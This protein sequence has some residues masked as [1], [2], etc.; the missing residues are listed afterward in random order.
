MAGAFETPLWRRVSTLGLSK[1]KNHAPCLNSPPATR[2]RQSTVGAAATATLRRSYC[3][4]LLKLPKS[5][6]A[7][8]SP[9]SAPCATSVA[10][11]QQ[12]PPVKHAGLITVKKR[13]GSPS[14]SVLLSGGSVLRTRPRKLTPFKRLSALSGEPAADFSPESSAAARDSRP[15]AAE[16]GAQPVNR[17]SFTCMTTACRFASTVASAPSPCLP[18]RKLVSARDDRLQHMSENELLRVLKSLSA[19][20]SRPQHT[21]FTKRHHPATDIHAPSS[22]SARPDLRTAST[23]LLRSVLHHLEHSPHVFFSILH[24]YAASSLPPLELLAALPAV[25]AKDPRRLQ[26]LSA[27]ELAL[28]LHAISRLWLSAGWRPQGAGSDLGSTSEKNEVGKVALQTI[29]G[30][31]QPQREGESL[32]FAAQRRDAGDTPERGDASSPLAPGQPPAW[33]N[34][35]RSQTDPRA[36]SKLG[37]V[38]DVLSLGPEAPW[39]ATFRAFED[40]CSACL[41]RQLRYSRNDLVTWSGQTPI[42]PHSSARQRLRPYPSAPREEPPQ[43]ARVRPATEGGIPMHSAPASASPSLV[44]L[45]ESEAFFAARLAAAQLEQGG[46][47]A[48]TRLS[49]A[50]EQKR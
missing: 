11:G 1:G 39:A 15:L 14:S 19:S 18:G 31:R 46:Q 26:S 42:Q 49:T 45:K 43:A 27:K 13:R 38:H 17:H 21:K 7:R 35:E 12:P 22:F 40:A 24:L 34:V 25:F 28:S 44:R 48:A 33:K 10:N 32:A 41:L 5:R 3:G 4:A 23:S 29:K 8:Q 47:Q 20:P 30:I 50:E 9:L 6:Q 16:A 2:L 36:A 37:G